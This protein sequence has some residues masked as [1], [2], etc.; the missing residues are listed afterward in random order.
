MTRTQVFIVLRHMAYDHG[1]AEFTGRFVIQQG[2]GL[3]TR[4]G[5]DAGFRNPHPAHPKEGDGLVKGFLLAHLRLQASYQR[6]SGINKVTALSDV[7]S[8]HRPPSVDACQ[9]AMM[10]RTFTR[11]EKGLRAIRERDGFTDNWIEF[12]FR[13]AEITQARVVVG[14]PGMKR[15]PRGLGRG[16]VEVWVSK[17]LELNRHRI[18]EVAL[19][20]PQN[21]GQKS[22]HLTFE[23]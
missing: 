4:P 18:R 21:R 14:A 1:L 19:L 16:E 23:I 6:G 8:Y 3:D 7:M 13:V 2:P 22:Q 5:G 15:T 10:A 11:L 20:K 17:V 9:A 12:V